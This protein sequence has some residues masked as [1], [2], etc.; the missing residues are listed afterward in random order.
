[1]GNTHILNAGHGTT[2]F[3]G[4]D[5]YSGMNI[6]YMGVEVNDF[7]DSDI[8]KFLRPAAEFLDEA[9]LTYR[10]IYPNDEFI[11]QLRELNEKLLEEQEQDGET[12]SQGS[13]IEAK[14]SSIRVE[15]ED[16]ESITGAKVH[17][18][19]VE[20]EDTTSVMGSVMSMG[21]ASVISK[22]P[23]LIDEGMEKKARH[24]FLQE[25]DYSTS[26][27]FYGLFLD[28]V[29]LK[30]NQKE[31]EIREEISGKMSKYQKERIFSSSKCSTAFK[32]Q[33]G[34]I[35]ADDK[36]ESLLSTNLPSYK[37]SSG[38]TRRL[39]E[40]ESLSARHSSTS[41]YQ[42][43]EGSHLNGYEYSKKLTEEDENMITYMESTRD[44]QRYSNVSEKEE[45][46]H[47][48][49]T[50]KFNRNFREDSPDLHLGETS[51]NL[52]NTRRPQTYQREDVGDSDNS[53]TSDF[54]TKRKY[55]QSMERSDEGGK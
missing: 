12:N 54:G 4:P 39:V 25:E 27:P 14:A 55:N 8:S 23:T 41:E 44:S 20:E 9:L 37:P 15:E 24:I 45:E 6:Q 22:Q 50:S 3:T 30:L 18:I 10:A 36:T 16:V 42:R 13:V 48:F 46:S 52:E 33:K 7:P 34:K 26:K 31:N 49:I 2:V 47:S 29:D 5:L 28:D 43:E 17:S 21:K 19:T 11:K 35:E 1:M 51:Y 40:N 53:D 38:R 32:K